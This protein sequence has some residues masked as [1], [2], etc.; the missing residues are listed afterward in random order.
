MVCYGIVRDQG[1][2]LL[3][4]QAHIIPSTC[5]QSDQGDQICSQMGNWYIQEISVKNLNIR[6]QGNIS[7]NWLNSEQVW[8]LQ[9]EKL[10]YRNLSRFFRISEIVIIIT[11]PNTICN[12]QICTKTLISLLITYS[13]PKKTQTALTSNSET[14]KTISACFFK[15]I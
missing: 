10:G 15:I 13:T 11:K 5:I 6:S 1:R 9:I 3:S 7:G 2:E 8:K 14:K 4:S 12:Y